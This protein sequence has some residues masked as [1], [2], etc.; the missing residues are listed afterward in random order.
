MKRLLYLNPILFTVIKSSIYG[1]ILIGIWYL[2]VLDSS[3]DPAK[4]KFGELSYTEIAQ[5]V[6]LLLLCI[7]YVIIA[8]KFPKVKGLALAFL[9]VY[10]SALAR[11]YN[12]YFHTW[13][14]GMWQTIVI[15]ILL[16]TTYLVNKNR[17]TL[18]KPLRKFVDTP[19]FGLTL[20]GILIVLIFSRLYGLHTIW[21]NILNADLTGSYRW[22]K[23]AAEEGTEL[24]GYS[25]LFFGA[26][27]YFFY[28]HRKQLI[29][30]NRDII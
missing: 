16:V 29:K 10:L 8:Y 28:N 3:S 12:N 2:M 13:F 17:L 5:E 22:I 6:F 19:S 9:G 14:S 23:N 7:V 27:D 26:I 11:E 18:L 20:C 15:V 4:G 30:K 24:L 25:F 1:S 21:F